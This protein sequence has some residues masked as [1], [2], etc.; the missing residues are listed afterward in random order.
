MT[1]PRGFGGGW[2]EP[3]EPQR[4]CRLGNF[5]SYRRECKLHQWTCYHDEAWIALR[6]I[7]VIALVLAVIVIGSMSN[8][9]SGEPIRQIIEGFNC[10]DLAQYVADK[11]SQY[12]YAEHRYEWLC[13]N[14]Q[15]KEF[16]G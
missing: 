11:N 3:E 16:Q 7:G 9:S 15:V 6:I 5:C 12:S 14:E 4:K 10:N 1:L 13:V 8:H 2:D